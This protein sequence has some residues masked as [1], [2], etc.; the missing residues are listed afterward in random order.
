MRRVICGFFIV[1]LSTMT[2]CAVVQPSGYV[3][4][5][6]WGANYTEDYIHEFWIQT[7]SGKDTGVGGVQLA[8]FSRGGKSGSICCSLMPGVGQ[9]IKVVWR[10]GGRQE[11][12]SEW[13]TY[14]KDVAV[15]G[16]TSSAPDAMNFLIV[17][18]FPGHNIEAEFVSESAEYDG[19][20]SPRVD[21]L[22]Y[23]RRVMR[24]MGE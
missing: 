8:E 17:R 7:A 2:G 14:S 15:A 23:G 4:A 18:F 13:K 10:V 5:S 6:A 21:Q 9:S 16:A 1:L 19:K 20:P 3:D 24:Q 12:R 11:T 22:F